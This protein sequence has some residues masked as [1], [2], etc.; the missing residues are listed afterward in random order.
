MSRLVAPALSIPSL[1]PGSGTS[2][3][4][5]APGSTARLGAPFLGAPA[6][7]HAAIAGVHEF[8]APKA[9]VLQAA[10]AAPE[11]ELPR[12]LQAP[13]LA[14][15]LALSADSDSSHDLRAHPAHDAHARPSIAGYPPAPSGYSPGLGYSEQSEP[16]SVGSLEES[17]WLD[18]DM[19]SGSAGH[20][21]N[22]ALS[23]YGAPAEWWHDSIILGRLSALA[24]R[25]FANKALQRPWAAW[26][27]LLELGRQKQREVLKHQ[28]QLAL[29]RWHRTS[30]LHG[31][32]LS[33]K[34]PLLGALQKILRSHLAPAWGRYRQAVFVQRD[35][36]RR[37]RLLHIIRRKMMNTMAQ[38]H[39]CQTLLR[40]GLA[41]LWLA[42]KSKEDAPPTPAS[43]EAP[44]T[45][46]ACTGFA[47][48]F[49]E[50]AQTG[51]L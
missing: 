17:Q 20:G 44:C 35:V 37:L 45:S 11:A 22:G 43:P 42:A 48:Y 25:Y 28:L 31:R 10:P 49:A 6:S 14:P 21:L 1:G 16:M 41:G 34:L 36:D 13:M 51:A 27:R 18:G 12:R 33:T 4:R 7:S 47:S 5:E 9:P 30:V 40:L 15:H 3:A 29:R 32:R 8:Q 19:G 26:R 2:G 23:T 39:Y 38:V 50:A 46:C 24:L